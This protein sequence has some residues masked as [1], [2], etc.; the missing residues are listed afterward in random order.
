MSGARAEWE[1]EETG[2]DAGGSR[3][4]DRSYRPG[5]R[6]GPYT[7]ERPLGRGGTCT[8]YLARDEETPRQV[9]LKVPRRERFHS[10]EEAAEYLRAVPT[11][12]R[13]QHPAIVAVY[14]VRREDDSGPFL[15]MEYVDGRSLKEVL[16]GG[17]MPAS[18]VAAMMAEVA[19]AVDYAHRRGFVHRDLKPANI[20]LDAKGKPH[21]VDFGLAV[22]ESDQRR[23]AGELAGTLPYMAPEQ[24][25]GEVPWI[26]GRADIW[27][28]GVML[29]EMLAGRRP[30]TGEGPAEVTEEILQR[31]PKPLR[32]I[33]A[34]IPSHL[35]R[36]CLKCLAK[37][38][39]DRYATAADLARDLKGFRWSRRRWLAGLLVGVAALA[40]LVAT[41]AW[42][43]KRATEPTAASPLSGTI[44]VMVW[45]AADRVRRGL[46]LTDPGALPL[47]PG[48]QIRVEARL[49]RPAYVYLV[50]IDALGQASPAYPW[51]SG[52]W[53]AR[54][55]EESPTDQLSLP[56]T[57]DHGWDVKP[58]YGTE[59]WVL[60]ARETPLPTEVDMQGLFVGLAPRPAS[61]LLAAVWFAQGKPVTK[62]ADSLRGFD[63]SQSSPID[64][65]LLRMQRLIQEQLSPHFTLIRAVTFVSRGEGR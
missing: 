44:D 37:R 55:D 51:R 45:N 59:T 47:R 65:A 15:V 18:R 28:L 30:F 6:I 7:I 14:D 36:I 63:P 31:E 34:S 58:P 19:A 12:A 52:R 49:S 13:L 22:H 24:I 9:A 43:L 3:E 35:E 25:R 32:Q 41:I 5:Q 62:V 64:D 61:N 1:D 40:A 17:P 11:V 33:N 56:P 57:A 20:L 42:G 4:Q 26:D 2:P 10:P 54:P 16:D 46:S 27:A 39:Q 60:L 38:V 48:D 50:A 8:V 53:T 29:Y 23:H 21:V